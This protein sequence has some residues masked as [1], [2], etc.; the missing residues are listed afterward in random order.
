MANYFQ[1]IAAAVTGPGTTGMTIST[2]AAIY[3]GAVSDLAVS[4]YLYLALIPICWALLKGMDAVAQAT[5]T[6]ISAIQST[7]MSAGGQAALGNYSMG[8]VSVGQQNISP[9]RSSAALFTQQDEVGTWRTRSATQVG[10]QQTRYALNELPYDASQRH[11]DTTSIRRAAEHQAN[12]SNEL[13]RSA[14]TNYG[15]AI[16]TLLGKGRFRNSDSTRSVTEGLGNRRSW[17]E[18]W[19]EEVNFLKQVA[20]DYNVDWTMLAST[21]A[22]LGAGAEISK[23]YDRG[24]SVSERDG[25]KQS[26]GESTVTGDGNGMKAGKA[27]EP[28]HTTKDSTSTEHSTTKGKSAGKRWE[29]GAHGGLSAGID[30]KAQ[31]SLAEATQSRESDAIVAYNFMRDPANGALLENFMDRTQGMSPQQRLAAMQIL[32]ADWA[33]NRPTRYLDGTEVI[34]DGDKLGAQHEAASRKLTPPPITPEQKADVDAQYQEF[35]QQQGVVV[36]GRPAKPAAFDK[37]RARIDGAVDSALKGEFVGGKGRFEYDA[38]LAMRILENDFYF[39]QTLAKWRMMGG[40]NVDLLNR[41]L[42]SFTYKDFNFAPAVEASKMVPHALGNEAANVYVTG[43]DAA[44][45]ALDWASG[46]G[47]GKDGGKQ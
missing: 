46:R 22:R 9:Q 3:G 1:T 43:K 26:H 28:R 6:G 40:S 2:S 45:S 39:N 36:L 7:A 34:W 16:G 33:A 17:D 8:G 13:A 47:N 31:A 21:Y 14:A 25:T 10:W 11:A 35:L 15:A 38:P 5:I 4:G 30:D 44:S 12:Q 18:A 42:F 27:G 23:Q 37:N 29:W 32:V 24:E 41:E 20:K 19:N